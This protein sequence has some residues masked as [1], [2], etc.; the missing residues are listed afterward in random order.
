MNDDPIF[1]LLLGSYFV[2]LA[3]EMRWPRRRERPGLAK[4]WVNNFGLTLIG[5]GLAH[6]SQAA[7]LLAAAWAAQSGG[8]GLLEQFRVGWFGA[9]LV[10]GFC[11]ELVG[12]A[13]HVAMHEVPFLWRF[14]AVHHSDTDLDVFS[15]YRHHP[16]E[17]V[18]VWLFS[19]PI[20]LV[21]APPASV[22][23]VVQATRMAVNIFSHA[24]I[25]VPEPIERR[26]RRF[27][28]TP[29]FHRLHHGSEMRYTNSNYGATVPWF[30]HLFGTASH[31]PFAEQATMELGLEYFRTPADWR[32]DRLLLMPFRS[33]PTQAACAGTDSMTKESR[34]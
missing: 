10:T 5:Q 1:L 2:C 25:H 34:C 4:R 28:V 3:W 14:H 22:I 29:D 21:L 18:F 17:Y 13:L 30:D 23:L 27:M 15:T 12:Y 26:L 33:F 20:V 11:F 6:A 16:G 19:V 7:T 8:A 31:R 32:L 24:N 9:L